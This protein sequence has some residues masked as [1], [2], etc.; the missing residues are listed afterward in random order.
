MSERYE[1]I[2]KTWGNWVETEETGITSNDAEVLADKARDM[3]AKFAG[4][5]CSAVQRF[6]TTRQASPSEGTSCEHS[7]EIG[8][9]RS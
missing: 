4:T 5:Q 7:R 9:H 8:R 3:N 2:V 1:I 6:W